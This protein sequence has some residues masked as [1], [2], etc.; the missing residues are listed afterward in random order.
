MINQESKANGK[1]A[2]GA[3]AGTGSLELIKSWQ[4]NETG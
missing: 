2:A 3:A 1:G 4:K